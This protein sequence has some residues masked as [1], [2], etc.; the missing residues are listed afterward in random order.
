[1]TKDKFGKFVKQ[2]ISRYA[3][4][5]VLMSGTTAQTDVLA[6][7][8]DETFIPFPD[9]TFHKCTMFP[10]SLQRHANNGQ[11]DQHP[12]LLLGMVSPHHPCCILSAIRRTC[13]VESLLH[14]RHDTLH[15]F[16]HHCR[17]ILHVY[18]VK[19]FKSL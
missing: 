3:N 15:C 9:A 18:K 8:R 2:K 13:N 16:L 7:S 14:V 4:S 10:N 11:C 19:N 6:F 5:N 17:H 1:M 12:S